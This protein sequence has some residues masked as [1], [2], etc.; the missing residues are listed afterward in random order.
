MVTLINPI[1]DTQVST[2]ET[3]R[4]T[5]NPPRPKLIF[6]ADRPAAIR[7][8]VETRFRALRVRRPQPAA[9]KS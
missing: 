8:G 3:S 5:D 9:N 1:T 7:Q 2:N 6:G 4:R